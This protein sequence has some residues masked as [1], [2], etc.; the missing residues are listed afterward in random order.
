MSQ[1]VHTLHKHGRI[2]KDMLDKVLK[3]IEENR[4]DKTGIKDGGDVGQPL[5]KQKKVNFLSFYT[6]C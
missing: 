3:F 1:M 5:K 2:D 4:F 6:H